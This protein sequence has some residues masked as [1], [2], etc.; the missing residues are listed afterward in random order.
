[1]ND[2][3]FYMHEDIIVGPV[4]TAALS[5][6]AAEGKLAPTD[7]VWAT[8]ASPATAVLARTIVT[9]PGT[10]PDWLGDVRAEERRAL[11]VSAPASPDWLEGVRQ[12]E[13]AEAAS[14]IVPTVEPMPM[15]KPVPPPIGKSPPPL[16]PRIEPVSP[17]KTISS[18]PTATGQSKLDIGSATSSGMVRP[19]NEDSFLVLNSSWANLDHRHEM[20]VVVVADGMGGHQ[21]GERASGLVIAAMA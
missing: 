5:S 15:P 19:R 17:R 8:G 12:A 16:P 14:G 11:A 9:F 6:L 13:E 18:S 7:A 4:P 1:M 2:N 3:W 20:A 10:V 21:A